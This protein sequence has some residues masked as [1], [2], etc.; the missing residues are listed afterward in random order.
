LKKAESGRDAQRGLVLSQRLLAEGNFNDALKENYRILTMMGKDSPGDIALFNMALIYAHYD[1]PERDYQ[2]SRNYLASLVNDFPESPLVEQANVWISIFDVIDETEQDTRIKEEEIVKLDNEVSRLTHRLE[3]QK[4]LT[5]WVYEKS[6]QESEKVLS[7]ND[8]SPLDGEALFNM[9]LNYAHYENPDKDLKKSVQYFK[10][11][12]EK[13]PKS[14][15]SERAK[16]WLG[17]LNIIEE[18]KQVDIEIEKKKK[19]LTQ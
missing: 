10:R 4:L 8:K 16:I 19:E 14:P 18:S 5:D 1:N 9:A 6:L 17:V 3:N 11:L 12:I 15:L 2:K 7:Q 13:Y